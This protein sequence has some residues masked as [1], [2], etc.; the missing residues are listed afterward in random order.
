MSR[1]A[2]VLRGYGVATH[3]A[4][5]IAAPITLGDL[6]TADPLD[7]RVRAW[8]RTA[9][10]RVYAAIPDFGGFVVKAD[11][12][13]RP[14]PFAYGRTHADGA[15][16][17]AAAL[18]P[19]GGTVFW[20]CFVYDCLQDW[21]DRSTDRAR[22]AADHFVPLDGAFAENVVLQVKHGPLDFQVREAISPLLTRLRRT[23]VAV[24]VQITQ[25]YTGQQR[26]V[27]YLGEQWA[28]ILSFEVGRDADGGPT[29]GELVSGPAERLG[30]LVAVSN[31]GAGY[32]WT[33][34]PFAQA[35][36]YA[37]GRLAWQPGLD[38]GAI[39]GEWIAASYDLDADA[40]SGLERILRGSWATYE[41]YTAPL[42]VGFMVEPGHHYGPNV[43]GYEYSRWG[44]YH[45]ADRDGVGVDRTSASG[46]GM[47]G[48]YPPGVAVRYETLD[49]CPDADLLFF[50]HVPYGHVLHSGTTVIQHIYD[51]HFAGVD[52][53]EAMRVEWDA[54]R[55]RFDETL[56]VEVDAR[57]AEQH[58][59]AVEWRDQVNTYFFRKSGVPDA[60]GRLIHP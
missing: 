51:S 55:D 30:G 23:N 24:E 25:E 26:H 57:L 44:T 52:G 29:L 53:V 49:A 31:V 16:L 33:G 36:L 54:I 58:R 59:C 18:A 13:G 21:R 43:D 22:A 11:S 60:R 10:E 17:L 50:H 41:S 9:V 32:H 35:N 46:S 45:F 27:C 15:N 34:H 20:R 42:G 47:V 6:D 39:L 48:L 7:D 4:A 8:W 1:T 19:F 37:Y 12:E 28:E 2:A 38:P 5:D 3:L 40:A 14:G 56:R